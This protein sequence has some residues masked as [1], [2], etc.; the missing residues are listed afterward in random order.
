MT[1][2]IKKPCIYKISKEFIVKDRTGS[3]EDYIYKDWFCTFFNL[4][5]KKRQCKFCKMKKEK[6]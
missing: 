3:G 5:I 4:K 2:T 1:V 6:T